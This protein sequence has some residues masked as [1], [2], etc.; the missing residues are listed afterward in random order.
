VNHI[1]VLDI[2]LDAFLDDVAHWCEP[3]QRLPMDEFQPWS[4]QRL[5]R[6]LEEKCGLSRL[7]PIPGRFKIEH[8]G[9]FAFLCEQADAA[10]HAVDVVHIDGHADLGMGEGSWLHLLSHHMHKPA[11]ERRFPP[12]RNGACTPG[13]YL[14]YACAAGV[15][16]SVRYVFPPGGGNDLMP[17]VFENN[18]PATGNIQLRGYDESY[19]RSAMSTFGRIDVEEA[20]CVGP[21]IPFRADRI[22]DFSFEG[23]PFVGAF[24]C[25]SPAFTPEGSDLLLKI[26]GRYIRF[27]AAS[28]ELP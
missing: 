17:F 26:L 18:D 20:T 19:L 16:A 22:E 8:D 23:L 2:D 3:G 25:Q 12:F 4:E 6:F 11:S 7:S 28:D 21:S 9:A 14:A 13:S 5:T 15:V 10:G 1:S 27:D 24:V